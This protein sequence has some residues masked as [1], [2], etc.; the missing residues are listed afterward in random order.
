[1]P[2]ISRFYGIS[3][4][5]FYN[6]H[7]PPHFHAIYAGSRASFEIA[8]LEIRKGGLPPRAVAFVVEWGRIHQAELLRDWEMAQRD[9]TP[10]PIAPLE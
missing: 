9:E 6:E 8:S 2:T 3:I 4:R 1:M 10:L 7:N 5:M